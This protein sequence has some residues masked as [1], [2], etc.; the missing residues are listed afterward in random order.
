MYPT[1]R[2]K[3]FSCPML[4]QYVILCNLPASV[5]VRLEVGFFIYLRT[6]LCG[7]LGPGPGF[8]NGDLLRREALSFSCIS[9]GL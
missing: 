5:A 4:F 3:S 6:A 7:K 2:L 8:N 9:N 1:S